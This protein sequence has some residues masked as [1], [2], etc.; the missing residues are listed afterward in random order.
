VK[1][2]ISTAQAL[3]AVFPYHA[4]FDGSG[5]VVACGPLLRRASP[6]L[7]GQAFPAVLAL[8]DIDADARLTLTMGGVALEGALVHLAGDRIAF[9]AGPVVRDDLALADL[10][11]RLGDDPDPGGEGWSDAQPRARKLEAV[12]QLAAGIAHEINTPVQYV[13]DSVHFLRD[14]F[15][16]V[17]GLLGR[18]RDEVGPVALAAEDAAADLP[19][20]DVQVPRAFDR[21]FEGTDRVAA[22]VRAMKEFARPDAR[23]MVP[24]DLNK[25]LLATLTVCRNEYRYHATVETELSDMPAIACHIGDLNQVFLN[26]I[27]NAA[28]AVADSGKSSDSGG[29]IRVRTNLE[30]GRLVVAIE[31]NGCGIPAEVAPR[32]FEPFFTTKEVGRGTGQGLAISHSIVRKH[33]GSLTFTTEPGRG[34]TFFVRL[35]E[36]RRDS[37]AESRSA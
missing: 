34:T 6:R 8:A 19:Y 37:A 22:I 15:N 9:L 16:E 11:E 26:L 14:A 17:R 7:V 20:L 35:P 25:A 24:A 27:V 13:S 12:G 31:D 30:A 2:V 5:L 1:A 32:I 28:H 3:D 4:V 21:I 10:A 23:D 29:R 36:K 33:G 18:Y